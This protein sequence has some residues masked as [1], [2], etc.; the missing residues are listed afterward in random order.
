MPA[1]NPST[2][3]RDLVGMLNSGRPRYEEPKPQ[4]PFADSIPSVEDI[5]T[6]VYEGDAEYPG[7]PKGY[8]LTPPKGA[9]KRGSRESI[10]AANQ[11]RLSGR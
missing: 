5:N 10:A 6:P 4:A 11:R 8:T 2:S 1:K 7:G 3:I 9:P